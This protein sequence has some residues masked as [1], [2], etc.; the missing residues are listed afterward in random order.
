ML[1]HWFLPFRPFSSSYRDRCD[2]F[3]SSALQRRFAARK[4][5]EMKDAL[6]AF[7]RLSSSGL[8]TY[9]LLFS[10]SSSTAKKWLPNSWLF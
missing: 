7:T 8:L 4:P 9:M 3:L 6:I 1:H 2:A 5:V 10:L